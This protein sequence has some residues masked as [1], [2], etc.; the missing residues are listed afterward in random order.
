M[1]LY[2]SGRHEGGPRRRRAG[3]GRRTA[4]WRA[5]AGPRESGAPGRGQDAG[6]S[7]EKPAGRRKPEHPADAAVQMH[8]LRRA[9]LPLERAEVMHLNPECRYP[10][11]YKLFVRE[12]VTGLVEAALIGVADE[13]AAQR[14]MLAGPLPDVGIGRPP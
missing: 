1:A 13:L 5:S 2:T 11:L 9:G 6:G 3:S 8:V 7:G 10:D 14:A 4:P 12:D